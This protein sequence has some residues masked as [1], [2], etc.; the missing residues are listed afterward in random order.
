M[1]VILDLC[2]GTGG[3]SR[4][5]ADAGYEVITVDLGDDAT[6]D[7]PDR[8]GLVRCDVRLWEPPQGLR[9][10]GILAAPPCTLFAVSGAR[11][12]QERDPDGARLRDG[13]SVVDACLRLVQVL[14]P[15]WWAM[16]NPVGRLR[17][18]VGPPRATF[19][20]WEYGDPYR[21]RTLLWGDFVMPQ[22]CHRTAPPGTDSRIHMASPGPDRARLRSVTPPHFAA[23]FMAANP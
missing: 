18:W 9:V 1:S 19:Q 13:L 23:A 15:D 10:H 17:R 12:W 21:K 14:S 8:P 22:R 4:P 16:E 2:G 20:P 3:W 5:Y 11:W 6:P 7:V